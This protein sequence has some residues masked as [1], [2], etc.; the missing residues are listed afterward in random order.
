M[1]CDFVRPRLFPLVMGVAAY[2]GTIL[3]Y[4]THCQASDHGHNPYPGAVAADKT[5]RFPQSLRRQN[6]PERAGYPQHVSRLAT[7]LPT[8]SPH[9]TG[10]YVGGGRL[11]LFRKNLDGRYAETDG[12]LGYDYTL[13]NRRPGRV[14]LNWWHGRPLE[15]GVGTYDP[16]GVHV[17][18]PVS[19]H[20]FQKLL[21]GGR[22][23]HEGEGA[24]GD[25][26]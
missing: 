5:H 8:L 21:T 12:T 24:E 7:L 20:F 17:P 15:P 4:A 11:V 23:H 19:R 13:F 10:G 16:D 22:E 9:Y 2:C 25:E 26:H 6:T 1:R 14:F 18:D 3:A